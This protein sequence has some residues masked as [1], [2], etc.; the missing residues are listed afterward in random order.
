MVELVLVEKNGCYEVAAVSTE[1]GS[2]SKVLPRLGRNVSMSTPAV[3]STGQCWTLSQREEKLLVE[4]C[5]W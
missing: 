5:F 1:S 4:N 2:V 3:S